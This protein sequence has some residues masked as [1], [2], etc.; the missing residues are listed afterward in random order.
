MAALGRW[1]GACLMGREF[2]T[3]KITA[4]MLNDIGQF[5]RG[6]VRVNNGGSVTTTETVVATTATTT[7][8][9]NR[10]YMLL[11]FLSFNTGSAALSDIFFHRIRLT[12]TAGTELVAS[13]IDPSANS[14]GPYSDVCGTF[15]FSGSSPTARTY[16]STLHRFSGDSSLQPA[17]N[18]FITMALLGDANDISSV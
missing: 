18:S 7:P 12:N 6:Q 9:A 14:A 4:A 1:I 11:A 5:K 2:F 3:G 16:V 8:V 15:F 10:W 13:R 17:I